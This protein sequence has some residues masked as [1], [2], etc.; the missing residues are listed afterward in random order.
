M[1]ARPAPRRGAARSARSWPTAAGTAG[2]CGATSPPA[3]SGCGA[4]S[5]EASCPRRRRPTQAKAVVVRERSAPRASLHS[6]RVRARVEAGAI[7]GGSTA[8]RARHA[9][10]PYLPRGPLLAVGVR[11]AGAAARIVFA[12]E[13]VAASGHRARTA[14][15]AAVGA[16]GASARAHVRRDGADALSRRLPAEPLVR[17]PLAHAATGAALGAGGAALPVGPTH[18]G[19]ILGHEP[20]E[21]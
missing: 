3:R 5:H 2:T 8:K 7:I 6:G 9:A 15:A 4:S 20:H 12:A 13:A 17:S 14:V 18:R 21:A 16:G 19:H 1:P 10:V 11:V